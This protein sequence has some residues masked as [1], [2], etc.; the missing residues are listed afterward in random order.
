MPEIKVAVL[1]D[2]NN[3]WLDKYIRQIEK[4]DNLK[5]R[6]CFYFSDSPEEI[7]NFDIVFIL[8]YTKI[9]KKAF[10][11]SNGLNLVVHESNLPEG[12]GFSPVQWQVLD[13]RNVITVCLLEA[14]DEVDSG[15]IFEKGLIELNGYEL[16]D[17]IRKKQASATI[18]L[19]RKF[20]DKYPN[21]VRTKQFGKETFYKKRTIEDDELDVDKTLRELFN[22][23]RIAHNEKNPLFFI[24]DGHQYYLKVYKDK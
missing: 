23:F 1:L 8:G 5:E 9:L 18:G 3:N 11:E 16:F 10:L 22:H 2:P 12:K 7:K 20:L 4:I 19:I 13:G 17:G 21:I 6:Y 15:D 24:I 14:T